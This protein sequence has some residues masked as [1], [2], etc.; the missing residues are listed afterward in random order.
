MADNQ[1]WGDDT[2]ITRGWSEYPHV[3]GWRTMGNFTLPLVVAEDAEACVVPVGMIMEAVGFPVA[4]DAEA[5]VVPTMLISDTPVVPI[6]GDAEACV[7]P[8]MFITSLPVFTV[9]DDAEACVV[10]TYLL[11]TYPDL[12]VAEDTETGVVPGHQLTTYPNFPVANDGAA[13]VTP[14]YFGQIYQEFLELGESTITTSLILPESRIDFEN[15]P[16]T[17][18][19]SLSPEAGTGTIYVDTV[20]LQLILP[21]GC[22]IDN[23]TTANILVKKP[24]GTLETWTGSVLAGDPGTRTSVE[25]TTVA[26]DLDQS[27]KYQLQAYVGVPA[28]STV[29]GEFSY[30]HVYRNFRGSSSQS[31]QNKQTFVD[32]EGTMI[33]CDTGV[34]LSSASDMVFHVLKPDGTE[35]EWGAEGYAAYGDYLVRRADSDDFDQVGRYRIQAEITV[36]GYTGRGKTA[37]FRVSPKWGR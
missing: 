35:E 6:A 11:S 15:T 19:T 4:G 22:A 26:D 28:V 16:F 21:V 9:A 7:V 10:P 37:L 17:E 34:D 31:S 32:D 13:A 27:G 30:L 25:Y 2:Y 36:G 23:A 14:V 12:P 20:G 29:R 3:F 5:C 1:P 18:T 33:V 24:D 8:T